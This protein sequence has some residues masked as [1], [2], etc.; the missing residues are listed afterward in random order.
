MFL[1]ALAVFAAVAPA[2]TGAYAR[3]GADDPFGDDRGGG[4]DDGPGHR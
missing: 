2:A 3:Q 1:L 4:G